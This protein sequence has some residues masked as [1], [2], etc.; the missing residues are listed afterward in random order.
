MEVS[1]N[2]SAKQARAMPRRARRRIN[3][4]ESPIPPPGDA[5][6]LRAWRRRHGRTPYTLFE[7]DGRGP[8]SQPMYLM[9]KY[10]A[11]KDWFAVR[12]C[13][14]HYTRPGEVVLDPFC[15]SGVTVAEALITGRKAIGVD[16]NPMATFIAEMVVTPVAEAALD[17]AFAEVEAT[18]ADRILTTYALRGHCERC[19]EKRLIAWYTVRGG[20]RAGEY[21]V[22]PLCLDCRRLHAERRILPAEAR[23]IEQLERRFDAVVAAEGLWYPREARL[24]YPDGNR[25]QQKRIPERFDEH[26]TPRNLLNAAR[27]F[28]AI[29]EVGDEGARRALT[30]AFTSHLACVSAMN[31]K[32]VSGSGWMMNRFYVPPDFYDECVWE[33]FCRTF[34]KLRAAMRQTRALVRSNEARIVC[35]DATDLSW[36][37]DTSVDYIFT[38]PPYGD[39]IDYYE[40]TA[41]WRCWL[42]MD[43]DHRREVVVNPQQGKGAE[44]FGDML[45]AAAREMYRVLKPGRW[46][47]VAFQNKDLGIWAQFRRAF[48]SAGFSLERVV[49]QPPCRKSFTMAWTELSPKTD[50]FVHFRRTGEREAQRRLPLDRSLEALV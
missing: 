25:F 8:R 23:A 10:W 3:A 6:R 36:L 40:L 22:A 21:V 39:S 44:D 15:G 7:A 18:V 32:K 49:P 29:R 37:D 4:I 47:T 43:M 9:H 27:L 38:D 28:K 34:R 1:A 2:L 35:G 33:R 19:G 50:V 46:A 13:I 45:A 16:L 31:G 12:A 20:L 48:S 17:A 11:R 14:E 26:F 24:Y 30:Y 42:G 41:F 5:Q